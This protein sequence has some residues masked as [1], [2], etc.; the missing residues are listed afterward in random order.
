MSHRPAGTHTSG[1]PIGT[2]ERQKPEQRCRAHPGDPEA[3]RRDDRLH[4][5]GAENP[6]HDA[7]HGRGGHR[8]ELGAAIAGDPLRDDTETIDDGVPVAEHEPGNEDR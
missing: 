8:R 1:G 2:G 5:R 6:E 4:E 3:D 7:A